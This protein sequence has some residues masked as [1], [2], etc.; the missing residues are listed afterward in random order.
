[1]IQ[2]F[3]KKMKTNKNK[4]WKCT[5]LVDI[6]FEYIEKIEKKKSVFQKWQSFI[7]HRI[8]QIH[9][10]PEIYYRVER[11]WISRSSLLLFHGHGRI[12]PRSILESACIMNVCHI[13]QLISVDRCQAK[14]F[15]RRRPDCVI[16]FQCLLSDE[17][18]SIAIDGLK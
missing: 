2:W 13:R 4:N 18:R 5:L 17:L 1:M 12:A 9:V 7:Q 15:A 8:L 16:D 3:Q 11:L 6:P 14:T 10:I